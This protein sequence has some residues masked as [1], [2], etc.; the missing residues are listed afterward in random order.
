[1]VLS[2]YLN[3]LYFM[4]VFILKKFFI[5]SSFRRV[6]G[7]GLTRSKKVFSLLGLNPNFKNKK[8]F[9]YNNLYINQDKLIDICKSIERSF[10]VDYELKSFYSSNIK[11]LK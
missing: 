8:F 9:K 4:R 11:I 10:L 3:K 2:R 5:L 6:F 7:I 1:M